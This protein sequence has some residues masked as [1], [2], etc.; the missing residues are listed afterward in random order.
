MIV[1]INYIPTVPDETLEAMRKQ[2]KP[3]LGHFGTA[4]YRE[5]DVSTADTKRTAFTW[6]DRKPFGG[7]MIF[8]HE[9]DEIITFHEWSSPSL[10]KPSLAEVY[11]AI[12]RMIPDYSGLR[13]FHLKTDTAKLIGPCHLCVC[14][15]FGEPMMTYPLGE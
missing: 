7:N 1:D 11:A 10:V 12:V 6:G 8:G 15:L 5:L 2:I 14:R 4:Y 9:Y 13:Y 3:V